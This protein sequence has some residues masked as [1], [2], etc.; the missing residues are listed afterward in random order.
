MGETWKERV[1]LKTSL[2]SMVNSIL[3]TSILILLTLTD[4]EKNSTVKMMDQRRAEI[5]V[6][7]TPSSKRDQGENSTVN[8]TST[9]MVNS[10]MMT[11]NHV[12]LKVTSTVK[13]TAIRTTVKAKMAVMVRTKMMKK[14]PKREEAKVER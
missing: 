6:E 4:S 8:S 7:K 13:K 11:A 1:N 14:A 10:V 2:S 5:R 3:T 9:L 12:D